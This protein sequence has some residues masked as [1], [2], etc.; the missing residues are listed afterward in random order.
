MQYFPIVLFLIFF[1]KPKL[2]FILLIINILMILFI[3]PSLYNWSTQRGGTDVVNSLELMLQIESLAYQPVIGILGYF[4][5]IV[6]SLFIGLKAP[7][8]LLYS[9]KLNLIT[10]VY[11]ES[12]FVLAIL[13]MAYIVQYIKIDR[14][15]K[16]LKK[17]HMYKLFIS[18]HH[19]AI[20]FLSISS[21]A[22]YL[23][24][25]YYLPLVI[26]WITNILI[27]YKL[28]YSIKKGVKSE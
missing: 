26:I 2:I 8:D 13:T 12:I 22:P 11:L 16:V 9:D 7:L 17:N 23:Q 5:R 18:N 10:L 21:I 19:I 4:L 24:P 14:Y 3:P 15:K 25:R 20:V 28:I 27:S 1:R 6:I